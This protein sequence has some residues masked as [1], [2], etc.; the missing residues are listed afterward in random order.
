MKKSY[1]LS[2]I[3]ATVLIFSQSMPVWAVSCT[4][5]Q[6]LGDGGSCTVDDGTVISVTNFG[7]RTGAITFG[8][9]FSISGSVGSTGTGTLATVTTG[10]GGAETIVGNLYTAATVVAGTGTLSAGTGVSKTTSAGAVS[11]GS[12]GGLTLSGTTNTIASIAFA[13]NAGTVT[14]GDGTNSIAGAVTSAGAGTGADGVGKLTF[15]GAGT[16]SGAT[17]VSDDYIGTITAN[18]AAGKTVAFSDNV[19]ASNLAITSTGAVTMAASGKLTTLNQVTFTGAGSL[20]LSDNTTASTITFT[21][22][23]LVTL[24]AGKT[25]TGNAVGSA[26]TGTGR[27]TFAG[28]GTLTGN[29]G[30]SS[31]LA[32]ITTS[33]GNV[34][35]SGNVGAD[36]INLGSY[37]LTMTGTSKVAYLSGSTV[38]FNASSGL[39]YGQIIN[40]AGSVNADAS[41]AVAALVQGF[42]PSNARLIIAGGSEEHR[43]NPLDQAS[44]T[45]TGA[46][47]LVFVQD[48]SD[49]TS[50]ALLATRPAFTN[51]NHVDLLNAITVN[52]INASSDLS[53]ILYNIDKL[54]VADAKQAYDQLTAVR[55]VQAPQIAQGALKATGKALKV[56]V[57]QR[58]AQAE[59]NTGLSAGGDVVSMD[60]RWLK[61]AQLW[62]KGF[63]TF[64]S[65]NDRDGLVGYENNVLGSALGL[66]GRYD[67]KTHLGV[68]LSYAS[69]NVH[70]N[71]AVSG[72]NVNAYQGTLYGVKELSSP[73]YVDGSLGLAWNSYNA[74]RGIVFNGLNRAAQAEY[75]GQQYAA[76]IGLGYRGEYRSW[77]VIPHGAIHYSKLHLAGYTETNAGDLNLD[78]DAQNYDAL[79]GDVG[80]QLNRAFRTAYGSVKP[81]VRVGVLRDFISEAE[82]VTSSFVGGGSSFNTEGLRAYRTAWTAGAGL[83]FESKGRWSLV[84]DYDWEAKRTY[85]A[86][87]VMLTAKVLL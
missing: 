14:I 86:Q 19:Y 54:S 26:E 6:S 76:N 31:H 5:E 58:L 47:N 50:L 15:S 18:G 66:D 38:N 71:D 17:G 48:L 3:A 29:A 77:N 57:S 28:T 20:A 8:G 27:L 73:W 67:A 75:D 56:R 25:L 4:G 61:D 21:S 44:I 82:N 79:Q 51:P 70:M 68:S 22:S 16:V 53:N 9:A 36:T 1:R 80:V 69:T 41:T 78:V 2:M 10:A 40:K 74:T 12:T 24:A 49:T 7:N 13:N 52:N 33:H 37:D 39:A 43:V 72:L 81:E 62:I 35:V 30:G 83:G 34:S 45:V 46:N 55:S 63:G 84:A 64:A 60:N 42:V 11:F 23:G 85:N 32:T 59:S 87:N 65:Q